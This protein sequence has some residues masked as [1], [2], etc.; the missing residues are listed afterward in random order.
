MVLKQ[1]V[2]AK[3]NSRRH[4]SDGEGGVGMSGLNNRIISLTGFGQGGGVHTFV[5][6]ITK[7]RIETSLFLLILTLL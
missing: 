2:C 4:Y 3:K 7:E 6:W 1:D 5:V